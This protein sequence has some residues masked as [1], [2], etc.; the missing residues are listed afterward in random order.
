MSTKRERLVESI[1]E[2]VDCSGRLRATLGGYETSL[3]KIAGR[4][5]NG[6]RAVSAG[7]GLSIPGDRRE[8]TETI[9]EFESARHQLRLALFAV[10]KEEGASISEVGRALGISRQLASRLAAE[11]ER[12]DT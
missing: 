1:T 10:G 6:A 7:K 11:A 3:L 2:L 4:L 9:Q 5:E 12:A 8:V